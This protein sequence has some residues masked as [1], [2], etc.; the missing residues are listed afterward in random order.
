MIHEGTMIFAGYPEHEAVA[1]EF[2]AHHEL[3]RD[4][5]RMVVRDERL[6]VI[7]KRDINLKGSVYGER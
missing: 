3:T 6:F 4:D 1:R 5:V 2:I 7:A